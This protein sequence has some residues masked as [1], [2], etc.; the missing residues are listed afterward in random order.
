M[1]KEELMVELKNAKQKYQERYNY[2]KNLCNDYID[3]S[4]LNAH[5]HEIDLCI[6]NI[7]MLL[8]WGAK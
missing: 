2:Y 3:C 6:K 8:K 7:N 4:V 5:M 1:T